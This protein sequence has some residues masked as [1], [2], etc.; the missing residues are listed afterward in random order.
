MLELFTT[1]TELYFSVIDGV[2]GPLVPEE[3]LFCDLFILTIICA[4]VL[5]IIFLFVTDSIEVDIRELN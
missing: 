3:N 2:T 1:P 4:A 5:A